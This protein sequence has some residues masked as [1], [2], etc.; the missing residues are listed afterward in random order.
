MINEARYQGEDTK[1]KS[2]MEEETE[3]RE[4]KYNQEV[5]IT[6]LSPPPPR[7][8]EAQMP[9][10]KWVFMQWYSWL[11]CLLSDINNFFL[12]IKF[13]LSFIRNMCVGGGRRRDGSIHDSRHTPSVFAVTLGQEG[14]LA[15]VVVTLH[16]VWCKCFQWL[17][18]KNELTSHALPTPQHALRCCKI[19]TFGKGLEVRLLLGSKLISKEEALILVALIPVRLRAPGFPS[20]VEENDPQMITN[21]F[22]FLSGNLSGRQNQASGGHE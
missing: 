20:P 14:A 2:K 8:R 3:K 9:M 16:T 15:S 11:F 10:R 21:C 5:G 18:S 7:D 13:T 6:P 4:V 19:Q 12:Y 17:C 22:H 1:Q